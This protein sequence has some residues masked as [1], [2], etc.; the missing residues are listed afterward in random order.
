MQKEYKAEAQ[1]MF[2]G[3]LKT[4]MMVEPVTFTHKEIKKGKEYMWKKAFDSIA[5]KVRLEIVFKE[6]VLI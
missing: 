5:K 2:P 6:D 1:L 4:P 3:K